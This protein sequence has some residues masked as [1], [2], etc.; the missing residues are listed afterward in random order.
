[1]VAENESVEDLTRV[2]V[3]TGASSGVGRAAAVEFARRGWV[4]ALVGRDQA[5]LDSATAAVR[6][7]AVA[8]GHDVTAKAVGSYQCDFAVLDDVRT[9]AAKLRAAYSRIDVLANNAGLVSKKRITTVDGHELTIQTNHL[10]PFLLTELLRDNLAGGR[11]IVT[12][13][14]AHGS[15]RLEPDDLDGARRRPYSAWL[16]YGSS[17]QANI[18]FAAEAARRWPQFHSY[19][20]HPGVVKTRFGTPAA[21]FFYRYAPAAFGLVTPEQGADTL[22]WLAT[23]PESGLV[24]GAYYVK[25]A[26]RTPQ[27]RSADP[28]LAA[29]LW[30]VSVKA[31]GLSEA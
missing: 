19:S 25:R 18:L 12:A 11:M 21:R 14:M 4:V 3:V 23:E 28:A 22:V 27:S 10:A 5:R 1:M 6:D 13:S 15:G 7:A 2:V 9:L 24:D 17:K 29:Q 16:A 30:D 26:Q 8:A 31:L 20:F